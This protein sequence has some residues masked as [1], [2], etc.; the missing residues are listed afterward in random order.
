MITSRLLLLFFIFA[1][2]DHRSSHALAPLLT[3]RR[4][5]ILCLII[6]TQ[7]AR[8]VFRGDRF[9]PARQRLPAQRYYR[10]H[11]SSMLLFHTTAHARASSCLRRQGDFD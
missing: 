2:R 6:S 4:A 5:A 10:Y 11:H 9:A 3:S 8:I 1:F 7:A